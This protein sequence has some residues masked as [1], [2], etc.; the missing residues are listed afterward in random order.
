MTEYDGTIEMPECVIGCGRLAA[1]SGWCERCDGILRDRIVGTRPRVPIDPTLAARIDSALAE[2]ARFRTMKAK[3]SRSVKALS[4]LEDETWA[5]RDRTS[6]EL[7]Q[8]FSIGGEAESY[9][10]AC[11]VREQ[12][13]LLSTQDRRRLLVRGFPLPGGHWL[14]IESNATKLDGSIIAKLSPWRSVLNAI[15]RNRATWDRWAAIDW[16]RL[17]SALSAAAIPIEEIDNH[18]AE[19]RYHPATRR[20][21]TWLRPLVIRNHPWPPALNRMQTG[22]FSS[23]GSLSESDWEHA[24]WL[25]RWR[26]ATDGFQNFE[27]MAGDPPRILLLSHGR[28]RMWV[29]DENKRSIILPANPDLWST[30]VSW[31]LSPPGSDE[32][33]MLDAISQGMCHSCWTEERIRPEDRRAAQLLWSTIDSLGDIDYDRR[34]G[35]LIVTGTSGAV[36]SI[37]SRDGAHGAPY[38]VHAARSVDRLRRDRQSAICLHDAPNQR[39]FP[40][41]DRLLRVVLTVRDDI[42]ASERIEPLRRVVRH[43]G[44]LTQRGG[45]EG[46]ARHIWDAN[47]RQRWLIALTRRAEGVPNRLRWTAVMPFVHERLQLAQR[48]DIML[49]P[50]E[51]GG[52]LR[53][54]ADD[55]P[56]R[57]I[58]DDE[59]ALV[60]ELAAAGGWVQHGRVNEQ[61]EDEYIREELRR[62]GRRQL[63]DMLTPYQDE[64]GGANAMPWWMIYDDAAR[65]RGAMPH[66]MPQALIQNLGLNP[67]DWVA[68]PE[69]EE[70]VEQ[71]EDIIVEGEAEPQIG[72]IGWRAQRMG[73]VLWRNEVA[74]PEEGDDPE[75]GDGLDEVPQVNPFNFDYRRFRLQQFGE[76]RFQI[77]LVP[78]PH[79][80][81]DDDEDDEDGIPAV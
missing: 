43:G 18:H 80:E 52:E 2:T 45:R 38:R 48:G 40:F 44:D 5:V 33:M 51:E 81:D 13:T 32:R 19:M 28:L 69:R 65:G 15:T 79:P 29:H 27:L 78:Q 26:D 53:F 77:D 20:I 57:L 22:V 36:Y 75:M 4:T 47:M 70:V 59:I 63:F 61:L 58:S 46:I 71:G 25:A 23:I 68:E 39:R 6:G 10:V 67:E 24:P 72:R 7:P 3:A 8:A 60:R 49:I 31:S 21:A 11:R 16:H 42:N 66:L 74:A 54:V 41:G 50:R 73:N 12:L 55:T 64:H 56:L 30:L 17:F 62:V 1:V 37:S 35:A 34:L 9:T 14:S 76:G